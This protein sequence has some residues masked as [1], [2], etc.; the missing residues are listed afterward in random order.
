MK[1]IKFLA[2][3]ALCVILIV[4]MFIQATLLVFAQEATL[5]LKEV[6]I[7]TGKTAEEAKSWL[8]Q[9]GYTVFDEDLNAGTGK[10]YAY[11][12]YKTTTNKDEAICDISMMSMDSGYKM[13][14]YG[15]MIKQSQKGIE[16]RASE[17]LVALSEFRANYAAGSPNA[18]I[19][20]ETL[21]IFRA[22]E[23]DSIP[24]GDYLLDPARTVS[25]ITDILLMSN[26][27]VFT[28]IYNQVVLGVADYNQ[29]GEDGAI[30]TWVDRLSEIG[31]LSDELTAAE[32]DELDDLYYE[33][34]EKLEYSISNFVEMLYDAIDRLD[35]NGNDELDIGESVQSPATSEDEAF[36]IIESMNSGTEVDASDMD[37]LLVAVY[38][39]LAEYEFGD[40]DV[41]WCFE[42]YW[43]EEDIRML[44]PLVMSL[45]DGQLAMMQISGVVNMTLAMQNTEEVYN[46]AKAQLDVY[47]AEL[48]EANNGVNPSVFLGVNKELY[49]EE[50]GLTTEAARV[51]ATSANYN[52]LT[53]E[54]ALRKDLKTA[55][56]VCGGIALAA[57][58]IVT[59]STTIVGAVVGASGFFA[60]LAC[61]ASSTMATVGSFAVSIATLGPAAI[62]VLAV[63]T[64][65]VVLTIWLVDII[66]EAWNDKHPEYTKI[67][68]SMYD[69]D[70]N[71][72]S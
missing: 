3:I 13:M 38:E 56:Q 33:K 65:I 23:N 47:G 34:A 14:N 44:Y 55:I 70:A 16:N 51:A 29:D 46:D 2:K 18:R 39:T 53:E 9:N 36:G 27:L 64:I 43:E 45:T 61:I 11:L 62:A 5:Y 63:V 42:N 15:E 25:D 22:G 7:S 54:N 30:K 48:I 50:V 12:G 68:A 31:P 71:S 17:M 52:Q 66:K 26:T 40:I 58:G 72:C 10:D 67:P 35:T 8:I 41:G 37:M 57:A 60:T 6:Q 59:I 69:Y 19:A 20:K 49:K 4:S 24:L 28:L 32:L 21:D 1:K